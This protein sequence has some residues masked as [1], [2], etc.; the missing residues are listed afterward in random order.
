MYFIFSVITFTNNFKNFASFLNISYT[1]GHLLKLSIF[2]KC[3]KKSTF[4]IGIKSKK[5]PIQF[6][7]VRS[8][9]KYLDEYLRCL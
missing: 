7:S 3:Y 9:S 1:E 2:N 5:M 8:R 4:V 6:D